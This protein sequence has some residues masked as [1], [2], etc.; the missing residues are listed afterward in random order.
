MPR[1]T[2]FHSSHATRPAVVPMTRDRRTEP[3]PDRLSPSHPRYA[4][5][6]A[7]HTA[8]L[9]TGE[10]AYVDPVTGYQVF[11][12]DELAARGTCCDSGCRHC[13]YIQ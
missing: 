1:F 4:E 10:P 5:I 8:A 3:H 9:D 7:V 13:P 12:A 2:L 6:V 11:T